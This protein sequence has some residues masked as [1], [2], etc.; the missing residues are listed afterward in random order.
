MQTVRYIVC[1]PSAN[2]PIPLQPVHAPLPFWRK[3]DF[4]S[5]SPSLVVRIK[6]P[7]VPPLP[8]LQCLGNM[9]KFPFYFPAL[10]YAVRAAQNNVQTRLP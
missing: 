10:P 6:Y 5:H 4:S 3:A 2:A 1:L 7:A 9:L 8:P